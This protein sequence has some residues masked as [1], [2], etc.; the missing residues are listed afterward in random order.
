VDERRGLSAKRLSSPE[1]FEIKQL[2]A[3]G[4]VSAAD[5]SDYDKIELIRRSTQI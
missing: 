2:I 1:R 4:A 5:V 3:S